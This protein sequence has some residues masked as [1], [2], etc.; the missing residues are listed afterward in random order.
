M[1]LYI[2]IQVGIYRHGIAGVFDRGEVAIDTAMKMLGLESDSYHDYEVIECELN[3]VA[4]MQGD[5]AHPEDKVIF[6]A[7]KKRELI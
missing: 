4:N 1:K 6:R 2:V 3:E 5:P 7:S